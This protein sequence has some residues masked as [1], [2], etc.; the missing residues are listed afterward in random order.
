MNP[1]ILKTPYDPLKDLAPISMAAEFANVPWCSPA[2][3]KTP[4]FVKPQSKPA[5]VT[6][7]SSGIGGAGHFPASF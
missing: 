5:T 7:A 3:R 4:D 1:H 2:Q 6:Y